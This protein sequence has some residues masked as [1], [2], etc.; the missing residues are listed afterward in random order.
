MLIWQSL[1][2]WCETYVLRTILTKFGLKKKLA[3]P[4]GTEGAHYGSP[5][6][7]NKIGFAIYECYR[8]QVGWAPLATNGSTGIVTVNTFRP[9]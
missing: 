7:S 2:K 8:N 4:L 6:L 1:I 3:V 9:I 5:R